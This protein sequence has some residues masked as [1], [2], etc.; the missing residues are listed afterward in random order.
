MPGLGDKKRLV[1]VVV[2]LLVNA[3]KYTPDGGHIRLKVEA[4]SD[5]IH[6]I[7]KMIE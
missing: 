2:N 4:H 3:A 6:L 5:C 7:V 1:Q